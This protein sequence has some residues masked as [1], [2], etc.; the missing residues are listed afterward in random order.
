MTESYFTLA[1]A[2]DKIPK[3]TCTLENIRESRLLRP[4]DAKKI[5]G[6]LS[7]GSSVYF[8]R[9]GRAML[10]PF[11]DQALRRDG[12]VSDELDRAAEWWLKVLTLNI[13]ERRNW[14]L[15]GDSV[16]HLFT[17]A[18]GKDAHLGAVLYCDGQWLWCHMDPPTEVLSAFYNRRDNQIMECVLLRACRVHCGAPFVQA[19]TPRRLDGFLLV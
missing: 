6:K 8:R 2:A 12:R 17:D 1:P 13:A 19:G 16:V 7:W 5:S 4:G 9:L 15:D 14:E 18:A 3:W 10:R 11:F